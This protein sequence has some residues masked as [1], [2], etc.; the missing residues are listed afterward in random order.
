MYEYHISPVRLSIERHSIVTYLPGALTVLTTVIRDCNGN[1]FDRGAAIRGFEQ[2]VHL[3]ND[4]APG[5]IPGRRL[6]TCISPAIEATKSRIE[7]IRM[8]SAHE[9]PRPGDN[10]MVEAPAPAPAPSN[11]VIFSFDCDEFLHM[12]G[13]KS[14]APT[15]SDPFAGHQMQPSLSLFQTDG[16]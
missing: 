9:V 1:D 13:F 4:I 14:F 15:P 7:K 5:F 6:Q 2:G 12:E 16:T 11:E 3:L 8:P 10:E